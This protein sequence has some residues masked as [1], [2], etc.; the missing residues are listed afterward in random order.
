[1]AQTVPSRHANRAQQSAPQLFRVGGSG[2]TA[3]HWQG[4]VIGFAQGVSHQSPGPVANP[5][6]IQPLNAGYPL[7]IITPAAIGPGTLQVNLY[8]MYN[9]KVWDQ[10]M[11]IV[12]NT[13][14]TGVQTN[15]LPLYNDLREVFIRLANIGKG[16]SCTKVIYPPNKVQTTKTQF[17]ADTYHNCVITDIRDDENIDIGSMEIV[18][19]LTIMYTHSTRSRASA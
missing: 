9:S 6:P 14:T 2:F 12:D 18:K 4:K 15:R 1:M 7:Q 5:V 8:E 10:I 17:Y 16:V 11:T 3:F 13:H 19:N